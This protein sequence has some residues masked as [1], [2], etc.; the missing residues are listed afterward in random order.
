MTDLFQVL[1]HIFSAFKTVLA[2]IGTCLFRHL[3]VTG[4]YINE[5]QIMALAHFKV[6]GIMCGS[7]FYSTR[8]KFGINKLIGYDRDLPV[9]N[10]QPYLL[11]YQVG[12]SL[13]LRID[14]NRC[15]TKICLRPG[16]CNSHAA[17]FS[18]KVIPDVPQF[19][20]RVLMFNF[21]V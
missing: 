10:W 21:Q 4:Q 1:K 2:L 20:L 14:S 15:I 9:N 11:S 12:I 17:L 19:A 13:I 16:G 3:S 5:R 18:N 8:A 7:Y 6:I